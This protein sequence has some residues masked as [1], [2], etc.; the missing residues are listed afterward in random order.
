MIGAVFHT[1]SARLS[2]E[3]ILYTINHAEGGVILV[4]AAFLEMLEPIRNRIDPGRRL[5]L[6]SDGDGGP[7]DA[8]SGQ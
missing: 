8:G 3:Q 1:I 4:N 7:R 5:A 2:H 6:L